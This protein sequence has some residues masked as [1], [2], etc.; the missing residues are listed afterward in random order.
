[1]LGLGGVQPSTILSRDPALGRTVQA[2][3]SMSAINPGAA[4]LG[5]PGYPGALAPPIN[6]RHVEGSVE[7]VCSRVATVDRLLW[8]MIAMGGQD[9]LHPIWVI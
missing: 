5:L 8:E 3:R 2:L 6:W 7:Q 4:E 1:L 9:I